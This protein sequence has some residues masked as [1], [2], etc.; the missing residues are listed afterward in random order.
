MKEITIQQYEKLFREK[1]HGIAHDGKPT[2][3]GKLTFKEAEKLCKRFNKTNTGVYT[4]YI[5]A[6]YVG[7]KFYA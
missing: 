6:K 1:C 3:L 4:P 7:M 2:D 5:L